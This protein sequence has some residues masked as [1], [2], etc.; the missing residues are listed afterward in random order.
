LLTAV[1]LAQALGYLQWLDALGVPVAIV[2]WV[3]LGGVVLW[4]AVDSRPAIAVAVY[5]ACLF[6]ESAGPMMSGAQPQFPWQASLY[7]A[8][9]AVVAAAAIWRLR[10]QGVP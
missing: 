7:A 5:I 6:V 4:M 9:A 3:I 10:R 8:G 1:P 2:V